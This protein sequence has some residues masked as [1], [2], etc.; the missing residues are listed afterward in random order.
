MLNETEDDGFLIDF[1]LAIKVN[2]DEPSGGAQRKIGTK[3]FMAIGALLGKPH[4][5]M[6]DLESFFWVLFWICAHCQGPK[7]P[8]KVMHRIVGPYEVWNRLDLESLA[9]LKCGVMVLFGRTEKYITDFCK[10]LVPRLEKLQ[11]ETISN[12]LGDK[13]EDEQLYS[14]VK[15][16]LIEAREDIKARPVGKF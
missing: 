11:N 3:I 8:G 1:H 5:F 4:T 12:G 16:I 9:T 14:R 10:P 7:E 2:R 15:N 6:H 13:I